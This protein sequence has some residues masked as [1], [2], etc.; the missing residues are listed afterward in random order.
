MYLKFKLKVLESQ[1]KIISKTVVLEM[2][3]I[4][5]TFYL[6]YELFRFSVKTDTKHYR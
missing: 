1:N 6:I 3:F 5:S 4:L 2:Y